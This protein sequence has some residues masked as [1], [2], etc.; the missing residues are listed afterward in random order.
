MMDAEHIDASPMLDIGILDRQTTT[1]DKPHK[2]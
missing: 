2:K 1:M